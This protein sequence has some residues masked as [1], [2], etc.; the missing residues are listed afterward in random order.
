MKTALFII[1]GILVIAVFAQ[2]GIVQNAEKTEQQKY[3]LIKQDGPVEIRFYPSAIMASVTVTGEYKQTSGKGFRILA[4]YIFGSNSEEEKIAMTAPVH[5]EQK[6]DGYRMSFVMPS[7]YDT[8]MLPV[9]D[10]S[11]IQIHQSE[12]VYTASIRFGG[13]ASDDKI[14]LYKQK[15]I[16]YLDQKSIS[17]EEPFTYLGYNPPY[18]TVNRRNEVMIRI[19]YEVIEAD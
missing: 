14:E 8:S 5:M 7:G 12:E 10:D 15:L 18:Q 17:Y 1:L 19:N 2:A 13:Y 3:E 9:P 4:S 6:D 16:E 11:Q